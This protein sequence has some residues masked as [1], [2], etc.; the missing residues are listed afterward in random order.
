MQAALQTNG[1]DLIMF[2]AP[3]TPDSRIAQITAVA[4]GFIYC[5]SLTGV[6]GARAALW[7]GLPTFLNRVRAQTALPL[8][9]GFG[10]STPEH[11]RSV[12]ACA[13]GAI[14]ASAIIN[15]LDATPRESQADAVVAYIQSLRSEI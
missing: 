7:D 6:T 13:D 14:V 9:V 4:S 15:I 10:I 1:L 5:V 3:T 8:V 12:A 11:V 2:V